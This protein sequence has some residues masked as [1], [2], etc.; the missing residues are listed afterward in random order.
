MVDL[1][2]N[3]IVPRVN[4]GKS[5]PNAA[6][7][8]AITP[9]HVLNTELSNT[10][11]IK[12]E[13]IQHISEYLDSLQI[14]YEASAQAYDEYQEECINGLR[15]LLK[16]PGISIYNKDYIQSVINVPRFADIGE[17]FKTAYLTN[18]L[19]LLNETKGSPLNINRLRDRG[20]LGGNGG[21]DII[22]QYV[23]RWQQKCN[24]QYGTI[25]QAH[26]DRIETIKQLYGA[27]WLKSISGKSLADNA[28]RHPQNRPDF[29]QIISQFKESL[30]SNTFLLHSAHRHRVQAFVQPLLI[31]SDP[32]SAFTSEVAFKRSFI[33]A[34]G[35]VAAKDGVAVDP[36]ILLQPKEELTG[37]QVVL[38]RNNYNKVNAAMLNGD[39][40]IVG[41]SE[42]TTCY[43]FTSGFVKMKTGT[44]QTSA[45]VIMVDDKALTAMQSFGINQEVTEAFFEQFMKTHTMAEHDYWHGVTIQHLQQAGVHYSNYTHQEYLRELEFHALF[46]HAQVVKQLFA[47]HPKRKEVVLR[48]A[49]D[50]FEQI[51]AM[52]TTML[53]YADN[54]SQRTQVQELVTYLAE[55]YAHRLFRV[56]A[57]S[58]PD[59]KKAAKEG[60]SVEDALS[61]LQL[62]TPWALQNDY[63][64]NSPSPFEQLIVNCEKSKL[65][66]GRFYD[67]IHTAKTTTIERSV[68][69]ATNESITTAQLLGR[70]VSATGQETAE[71][72]T[73]SGSLYG[74]KAAIQNCLEANKSSIS[75]IKLL[76]NT[77]HTAAGVVLRQQDKPGRSNAEKQLQEK[78][79]A[80][81]VAQENMPNSK[82]LEKIF[83]AMTMVKNVLEGQKNTPKAIAR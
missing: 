20:G 57:P 32:S 24:E 74:L 39:D 2:T 9:E 82:V 27:D 46:A 17:I 33:D 13:A 50:A 83:A 70:L 23:G 3:I 12:Q 54:D 30:P 15:E 75:D 21:K 60:K 1:P 63:P 11:T 67:A 29:G 41:P 34:L 53:E 71:Q 52:Q 28:S 48:W 68:F 5:M 16:R 45:S 40:L 72:H 73:R 66:H 42:G 58:D 10:E 31:T 47:E 76:L 56:I 77:M 51:H 81:Q 78:M 69:N 43:Q 8:M 44:H 37:S 7:R 38:L 35:V 18:S 64:C 80:L 4:A 65:P 14:A 62:I 49:V 25:L 36:T 19:E 6:G 79:A 61:P 55:I 26:A 22:A 59:L